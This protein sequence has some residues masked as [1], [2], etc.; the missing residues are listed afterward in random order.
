MILDEVKKVIKQNCKKQ[1]RNIT[2]GVVVAFLLGT[3]G[4]YAADKSKDIYIEEINGAVTVTQNGT[5]ITAIEKDV[6]VEGNKI[7]FG[8]TFNS[9]DREIFTDKSVNKLE[10]E[11]HGSITNGIILYN[12]TEGS[13]DPSAK[14][15][16]RNYIL[17]N[18]GLI[19]GNSNNF[20]INSWGDRFHGWG[21][22]INSKDFTEKIKVTLENEGIIAGKYTSPD[23]DKNT[24][25]TAINILENY[26]IKNKGMIKGTYVSNNAQDDSGNGIEV[27]DE[28]QSKG[29]TI[30]NE[31][32]VL[33]QEEKKYTGSNRSGYAN[34]ANGIL[35]IYRIDKI[36]NKGFV[37]GKSTG[38][39]I[40]AGGGGESSPG[41]GTGI[42]LAYHVGN[43]DI[44][45]TGMILGSNLTER[46]QFYIGEVG[47]GIYYAATL[48][49]EE[50]KKT[51]TNKGA[52]IGESLLTP[53]EVDD[54]YVDNYYGYD[55]GSDSGTGVYIEEAILSQITNIGIISGK[56]RCNSSKPEPNSPSAN[57]K[58][59]S[60][61]GIL[62]FYQIND[63]NNIG[64]IFGKNNN[65]NK[66]SG[67][68]NKE[69]LGNGIYN[70]IAEKEHDNAKLK[71]ITNYGVIG[72]S[73][74]AIGGAAP[75]NKVNY[76][77]LVSENKNYNGPN[78]GKVEIEAGANGVQN[79]VIDLDGK[80]QQVLGQ[81]YIINGAEKDKT[82]YCCKSY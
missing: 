7:I 18:T 11:N 48:D 63:I 65:E 31:G 75:E 16:E 23:D 79:V 37:L 53:G 13:Y 43:N 71:N 61:N 73:H 20:V 76:G 33:G 14:L 46:K 29:N 35:A 64:V 62:N 12:L 28:F 26:N 49:S 51:L 47:T 17:T 59:H 25:G 55:G 27:A 44:I 67:Y 1:G 40:R 66:G 41:T 42:G 32:V 5:P 4:A 22:Y 54:K 69:S 19:V 30:I 74:K 8:E 9:G 50:K 72:G 15:E 10:I 80:D 3:M 70:Y 82:G 6:K 21:I 34:T 77:L 68:K 57:D 38:E 52:I 36:T 24:G 78:K 56:S 39:D 58:T 81:R 2:T 45:N 60:G